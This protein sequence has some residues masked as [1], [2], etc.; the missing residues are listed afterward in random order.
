MLS[1]QVIN[2]Q[3]KDFI[4][5]HF[6]LARN[7]NLHNDDPLLEN[8]ILDSLGVLD[9]VTYLEKEF[10]ISISDE[11]LVPENFQTIGHIAAFVQG[12]SKANSGQLP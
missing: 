5:K 10:G 2:E 7:R 1:M 6:P 3:V 11:D 4:I 9:L 8:G 12:K